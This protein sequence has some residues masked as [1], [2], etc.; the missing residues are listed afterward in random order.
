MGLGL[1]LILWSRDKNSSV[2]SDGLESQE[3]RYVDVQ[4]Q[5]KK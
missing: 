5:I 4:G 2:D 1:L 3:M